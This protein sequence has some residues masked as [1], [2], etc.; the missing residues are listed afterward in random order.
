MRKLYLWVS[1]G[2]L[3]ALA[4]ILAWERDRV[5]VLNKMYSSAIIDEAGWACCY[6]EILNDGKLSDAE[7]LS[8]LRLTSSAEL[9]PLIA[10]LDSLSIVDTNALKIKNRLIELKNSRGASPQ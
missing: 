8:R 6:A 10:Q 2:V 4:L 3:V 7:K 5:Y 9:L 1:A